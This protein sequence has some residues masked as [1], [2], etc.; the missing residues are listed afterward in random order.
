MRAAYCWT[1]ASA[2]GAVVTSPHVGADF[3]ALAL[4][5]ELLRPFWTRCWACAFARAARSRCVPAFWLCVGGVA[6]W[7][8]PTSPAS[9]N[10][11]SGVPRPIRAGTRSPGRRRSASRGSRIIP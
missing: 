8:W 7:A 10:G 5:G 6:I 11:W 1:G 9:P 4:G 2:A 3:V